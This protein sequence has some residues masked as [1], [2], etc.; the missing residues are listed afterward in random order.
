MSAIDPITLVASVM[1]FAQANQRAKAE[2]SAAQS[3]AESQVRQIKSAQ[4]IEARR[5][6]DRLKRAM[7]TQRARY[8][9]SGVGGTGGSSRALLQGLVDDT[10][11]GITD[12]RKTNQMKIDDIYRD[13]SH[14]RRRS[15]LDRRSA[16]TGL[17]LD[18]ARQGTSSL[19]DR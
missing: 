1:S 14:R 8:G 2:A 7:A 15:L 4:E 5:E 10:E 9:A 17:A 3:Q 16:A 12:M 6:R 19:L 13:L 11:E 18:L